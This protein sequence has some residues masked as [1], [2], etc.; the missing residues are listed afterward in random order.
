MVLRIVKEL[1]PVSD[2]GYA[3]PFVPPKMIVN[4]FSFVSRLELSKLVFIWFHYL[5]SVGR[6]HFGGKDQP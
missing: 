1:G 6:D 3:Y 4:S 5:E 2:I